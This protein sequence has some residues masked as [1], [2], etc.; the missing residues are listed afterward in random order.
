MIVGLNV[1]LPQHRITWVRSL[2]FRIVSIRLAYGSIHGRLFDYLSLSGKTQPPC[3]WNRLAAAQ[4][5]KE[6]RRRKISGFCSAH[7]TIPVAAT[8]SF[9]DMRT[10]F[11]GHPVWTEDQW[12]SRSYFR[13][14]QLG[15]PTLW[16]EQ[17]LA[18][19]FPHCWGW[20][21]V[22]Q[23]HLASYGSWHRV[24][25]RMESSPLILWLI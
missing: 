14:G 7:S 18:S 9:A 19:Q 16:T 13:L 1:T 6:Y 3:G 21:F 12:F 25:V 10:R 24:R 4:I 17:L 11:S 23:T 8:N 15:Y 22:W 20:G 2:N 5:K